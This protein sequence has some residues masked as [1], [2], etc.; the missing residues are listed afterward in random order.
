MLLALFCGLVAGLVAA[1]SRITL[2]PT[3]FGDAKSEESTGGGAAGVV[4]GDPPRSLKLLKS[5]PTEPTFFTIELSAFAAVGLIIFICFCAVTCWG[6][7]FRG[8]I[9][10]PD[11]DSSVEHFLPPEPND[12]LQPLRNEYLAAQPEYEAAAL[13]APESRSDY[14][15]GGACCICHYR[16]AEMVNVPCGHVCLCARCAASVAGRGA[17]SVTG[18]CPICREM[19]SQ[20]FKIYAS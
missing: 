12:H 6:L 2:Q 20:C 11:D 9:S 18:R 4:D 10:H 13:V 7:Q 14:F 19:V 5:T 15:V 16:A 1:E 3:T 8:T 17:A